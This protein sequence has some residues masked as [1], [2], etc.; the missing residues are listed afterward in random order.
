MS[1]ALAPTIEVALRAEALRPP[2]ALARRHAYSIR[3]LERAAP[4]VSDRTFVKFGPIVVHARVLLGEHGI[5]LTEDRGR[6]WYWHGAFIFSPPG[7]L[8][9]SSLS[10][11][12]RIEPP[13]YVKLTANVLYKWPRDEKVPS[14]LAGFELQRVLASSGHPLR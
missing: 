14:R 9:L 7:N 2:S 5:G 13:C 4:S 6:D 8:E 3:E 10:C 11:E 12:P 1:A